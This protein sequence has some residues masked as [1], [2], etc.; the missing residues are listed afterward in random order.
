MTTPPSTT[1]ASPNIVKA[2]GEEP[3]FQVGDQ[4]VISERFPVGHYRV[5]QYMR[6]KR[7]FIEALIKPAAINNE[8]EG[9]GKNAGVK[10]YYYRVGLPLSDIWPG[11]V[12]S[13]QDSLRIEVFENWLERK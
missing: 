10:G 4:V 12:G 1:K 11:Y 2:T 5:P 3:L 8:T 7:V 9:F 6:G 13:P